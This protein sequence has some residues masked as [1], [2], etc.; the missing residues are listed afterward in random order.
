MKLSFIKVVSGV[1]LIVAVASCKP[2]NVISQAT[3]DDN[4]I[5]TYLTNNSLSATKTGSGLYYLITT[6]GTGPQPTINSSIIV[7]YKGYLVDGTVFDQSKTGGFPTKLTNVIV[8]WQQG[9][10]YFKKGGKGKLFIPSALGYGTTAQ[11]TIP[12][13][14]VLIFDIELLDVQ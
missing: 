10:P 8:G 13:S 9:L 2:K 7:N 6:Q 4:K 11:G 12:A 14:S 5:N 3:A 1:L